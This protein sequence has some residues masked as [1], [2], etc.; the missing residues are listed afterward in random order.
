MKLLL[1]LAYRAKHAF[2]YIHMHFDSTGECR[3]MGVRVLLPFPLSAHA[4]GYTLDD[5]TMLDVR[6][7]G[8]QNADTGQV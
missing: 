3:K 2:T 5:Y 6:R 1:L 7:Y 4:A 8:V